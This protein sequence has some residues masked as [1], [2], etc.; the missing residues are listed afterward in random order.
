MLRYT[1][2]SPR[3]RGS[4]AEQVGLH[5]GLGPIPADAGEPWGSVNDRTGD[6]AYPRGRG[7]A[8]SVT[9]WRSL[10]LGLS[11]RTRGSQ[12]VDGVAQLADGPI[13]ADAGEP[14]CPSWSAHSSTAYPRGRGGAAVVVFLHDLNQGLSPRTRGSRG[15]GL[16]AGGE[17][18]PI[19][20]DAGEPLDRAHARVFP[21]AYPRGRGG[22]VDDEA[23][24]VELAGLSPRTRGS[25]IEARPPRLWPGPIPADAGEPL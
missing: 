9:G 17:A 15:G 13:P 1:G 18:G 11:P 3:T 20:A 14:N 8:T 19:P 22:A 24:T 10:H 2:L 6:R 21:G 16:P 25:H 23:R 12:P 5:L 4:P 7:G